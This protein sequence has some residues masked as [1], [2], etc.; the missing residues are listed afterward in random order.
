M[1]KF[2]KVSTTIP[3]GKSE[4]NPIPCGGRQLR[5]IG[6]PV[7]EAG[8]VALEGS[9]ISFLGCFD[10]SPF[11]VV[12]EPGGQPLQVKTM[13]SVPNPAHIP[14]FLPAEKVILPVANP[15]WF[16]GFVALIPVTD[17]VQS[18]DRTLDFYF[19]DR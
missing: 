7:D 17:L 19:S 1:S 16:E 12:R 8:R 6:V 9:A 4:G 18:E 3:Q 5:V 2:L 13:V 11:F 10:I 14:N 15:S